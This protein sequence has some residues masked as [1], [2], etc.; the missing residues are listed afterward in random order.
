MDQP[1]SSETELLDEN[2]KGQD[3]PDVSANSNTSRAFLESAAGWVKESKNPAVSENSNLKR[4][5]DLALYR[6]TR[7]DAAAASAMSVGVYGAS[8]AGKSYLVSALAKGKGESVSARVGEREV[9]FLTDINPSG[10]KESTGLVTRFTYRPA[11]ASNDFPIKITM[12]SELD[13]V[14]VIANSFYEDIGADADL[15]IVPRIASAQ[16]ILA[17]KLPLGPSSVTIEDVVDLSYYCD[18]HFAN[19]KYY[20]ALKQ[21]GYWARLEQLTPSCDLR[22]RQ[23]LYS[24]L[25][26]QSSPYDRLFEH[27]SNSLARL[28][29]TTTVM[30]EPSALFDIN[31]EDWTRTENSIINVVALE[32]LGSGTE[33]QVR[34]LTGGKFAVTPTLVGSGT[35]S[36]LAAEITINIAGSPHE[37]FAEADLLDFPGAR[38]RHPID[39]KRFDET[40]G[41]PIEHFL[42]GKVAFL[43]ERYCNTF[44]MS[45]LIL[46]VGPS[47]QE[48]VGLNRLI[49]DWIAD[50]VGASPEKRDGLPVTLFVV[51][52]KFDTEFGMDLGK[53]TDESRWN[54]RLTASLVKPFGGHQSPV[55]QWLDH[56]SASSA[57]R[58]TYW[59][60][61]P[62]ADQPGLI[63]YGP[64]RVE[65]S[66]RKSRAEDLANLQQSYL[67][68]EMVRR[69]FADP[70]E[71]W[72]RAL[73]LNDGGAGYIVEN[74]SKVCRKELRDYQINA[75]Y[76]LNCE[77]VEKQL[78]GFH[79]GGNLDEMR[80]KKIKLADTFLRTAAG[81]LQ[82]RCAGDFISSIVMDE[83]S[84]LQLYEEIRSD[85]K[86]NTRSSKA[87][88]VHEDLDRE[89]LALLGLT[90]DV[91]QPG[92]PISQSVALVRAFVALWA[93]NLC[94]RFQNSEHLERFGIDFGFV[95][96]IAAESVIGF[97]R[98]GGINS[99]AAILDRQ[100]YQSDR[101]W[102]AAMILTTLLNDFLI[103]TTSG[104]E[105]AREVTRVDGTTVG[106]FQRPLAAA[107][108][109]GSLALSEGSRTYARQFLADWAMGFYDLIKKNAFV[110][111]KDEQMIKENQS[112]GSV[113]QGFS[114]LQDA[115]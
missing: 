48:V 75:Q 9:N 1:R 82:R 69:H 86:W 50:A 94:A 99:V 47:N 114:R 95:E 57:F 98:L 27:L 60:R 13:L 4:R 71:A 19:Q 20:A 25:W 61:S 91:P 105:R 2:M 44:G 55:T 93:S 73:K 112:L 79:V 88:Q 67:A 24:L 28:G 101:T 72:H 59:W 6:Q 14:K 68:S 53:A 7:L 77:A 51:L 32:A 111:L 58:N 84:G 107:V 3:L 23:K 34:V 30:C 108:Q 97:E 42:R 33:R 17:E 80:T 18:K 26:D 74:L 10:G 78:L 92:I 49:E 39:R 64:D 85:L 87:A 83:Q 66:L 110:E 89:A 100:P 52:T 41:L 56:W 37:F 46:C 106:L 63:E 29:G 11:E 36:A 8:Q 109:A 45:C 96:T 103:Y 102:K 5:I 35:L 31:G 22:A 54:T 12:L 104:S 38:S 16:Q 40:Q 90:D 70:D 43:F 115:K 113:L 21:V 15:D 62:S 76:R 65:A 81:M